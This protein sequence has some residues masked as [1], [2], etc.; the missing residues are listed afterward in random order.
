[1]EHYDDDDA[2][3]SQK[4]SYY[5]S[6]MRRIKMKLKA[7]HDSSDDNDMVDSSDKSIDLR[8][9]ANVK[10]NVGTTS[11]FD[12]VQD[13]IELINEVENVLSSSSSWNKVQGVPYRTYTNGLYGVFSDKKIYKWMID[14]FLLRLGGI[15]GVTRVDDIQNFVTFISSQKDKKTGKYQQLV[16]L[17]HRDFKQSELDT[18]H[19]NWYIAFIPMTDS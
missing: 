6:N 1:M 19:N 8:D 17:Y 14:E 7:K 15:F 18:A 4:I 11:P 3:E 12:L 9:G 2:N 10:V 16:Q 5:T 13:D